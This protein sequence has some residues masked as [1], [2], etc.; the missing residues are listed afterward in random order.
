[1]CFVCLCKNG[2]RKASPLFSIGRFSFFHVSRQSVRIQFVLLIS[3]VDGDV[4]TNFGWMNDVLRVRIRYSNFNHSLYVLIS[5][6][7]KRRGQRGFIYKWR[8]TRCTVQ[9]ASHRGNISFNLGLRST[10]ACTLTKHILYICRYMPV[11]FSNGNG[12]ME[13]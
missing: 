8:A 1:M 10:D 9:Y 13:R 11:R 4:A 6:W 2:F 3:I 12:L 7:T 5:S